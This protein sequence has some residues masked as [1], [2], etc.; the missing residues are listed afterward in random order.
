MK[1]RLHY[2]MLPEIQPVL[3]GGS[4]KPFRKKYVYCKRRLR[5]SMLSKKLNLCH[6]ETCLNWIKEKRDYVVVFMLKIIKETSLLETDP[7]QCSCSR[8]D[9]WRVYLRPILGDRTSVKIQTSSSLS[10]F[11]LYRDGRWLLQL[12]RGP[13]VSS[14]PF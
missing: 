3:R 2:S 12:I 6:T 8:T 1:H 10:L 5:Y 9:R 4:F 7:S 11:R 14:R 13:C